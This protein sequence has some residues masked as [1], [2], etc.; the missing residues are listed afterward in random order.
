VTVG[1]PQLFLLPFYIPLEFRDNPR[2][3]HRRKLRPGQRMT[4]HSFD[5]AIIRTGSR[6]CGKLF[7]G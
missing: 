7:G 5:L 4:E 1:T 2:L 3:V 6:K